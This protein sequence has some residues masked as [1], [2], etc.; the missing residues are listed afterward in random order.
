MPLPFPLSKADS[1]PVLPVAF[2]PS[3]VPSSD[4]SITTIATSAPVEREKVQAPVDLQALKHAVD[5]EAQPEVKSGPGSQPRL[6]RLPTWISFWLGYRKTLPPPE[7]NYVVWIWSF[8]GAFSCISAIQG[9]FG[10]VPF[11]VEKGVPSI[12]SYGHA[13]YSS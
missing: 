7:K 13:P 11:F 8:I 6:A 4:A 12:V 5:I 3:P 9:L 10:N 2:T 1:E